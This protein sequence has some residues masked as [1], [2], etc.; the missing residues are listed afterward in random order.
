MSYEVLT[1]GLNNVLSK[2]D[3]FA[4]IVAG[5]CHDANHDGFTNIYN[6]QTQRPLGILFK[7]QSVMETH[8]CSV[9]IRVISDPERNIFEALS[10][11]ELK[12]LWGVIIALILG[13]DMAK[14]FTFLKEV[15]EVL[16]EGPLD[17]T[18]PAK[19]LYLMGLILKCGDISNVSRPFELA[20]KWCDVLCEEFFRQGDLEKTQGMEYSSPLNDREHLDK[21]KSQIGFYQFVC[22][23][24]YETTARAVPALQVNVEQVKANLAIW[25]EA[26]G[27][28]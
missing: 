7:N 11:V 9:A 23:P 8:H 27:S 14:H 26:S 24:L 20:D 2:F 5:I 13:T 6:V 16:N 18:S 17:L 15:N 21:A 25:K 22:V 3:L 1:A 19:R 10:P 28:T 12:D 4:L